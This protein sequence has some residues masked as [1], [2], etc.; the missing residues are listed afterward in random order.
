MRVTFTFQGETY[1]YDANGITLRQLDEIKK[2]YGWGWVDLQD[3]ASRGDPDALR[4][5]LWIAKAQSNFAPG[6]MRTYDFP[7]GEFFDAFNAGVIETAAKQAGEP[8]PK[9]SP[10]PDS[11]E[12][13][14]N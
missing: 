8:D 5:V 12:T 2:N 11:T 3:G 14:E 4:A 6:D 9:A 1:D 7:A 13:S 10:T